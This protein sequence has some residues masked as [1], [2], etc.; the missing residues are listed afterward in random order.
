MFDHETLDGPRDDLFIY[1]PNAGFRGTDTFVYQISDGNATDE[2]TV[3]INVNG[4][5]E[6]IDDTV[7][8]QIE[9]SLTVNVLANDSDPDG[10]P[11]MTQIE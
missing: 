1:I 4:K 11:L 5:L 7:L 3:N 10:D 2:A 8:A 6:A 9:Q